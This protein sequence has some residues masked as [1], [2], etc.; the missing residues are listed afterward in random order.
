MHAYHQERVTRFVH[1]IAWQGNQVGKPPGFLF[2]REKKF[3]GNRLYFLIYDEWKTI[4]LV[5]IGVKKTQS[6][7]IELIKENLPSYRK[8]VYKML[9]TEGFI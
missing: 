6:E 2:F 3:N 1:Q 8:Y 7:T 5:S 9:K 4:L